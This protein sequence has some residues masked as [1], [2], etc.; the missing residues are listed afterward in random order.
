MSVGVR[1]PSVIAGFAE[2]WPSV[3][4]ARRSPVDNREAV[5]AEADRRHPCRFDVF[6]SNACASRNGTYSP[7]LPGPRDEA[8]SRLVCGQGMCQWLAA[9]SRSPAEP[10][11]LRRLFSRIDGRIRDRLAFAVAG[12]TDVAVLATERRRLTGVVCRIDS[13]RE[14]RRPSVLFGAQ[15]MPAC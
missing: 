6:V 7:N 12:K 13:T 9:C 14:S 8:R 10:R 11:L 5:E 2:L 1:L 3:H 4:V 15:V